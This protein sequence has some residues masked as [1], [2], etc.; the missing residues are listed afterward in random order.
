MNYNIDGW[1]TLSRQPCRLLISRLTC[2]GTVFRRRSLAKVHC[3]T[4]F[5]RGWMIVCDGLETIDGRRLSASNFICKLKPDVF[6]FFPVVDALVLF[7]E[8]VILWACL[9]IDIWVKC[10]LW[11]LLIHVLWRCGWS[12][13]TNCFLHS[14]VSFVYLWPICL[15]FV[16]LGICS[17]GFGCKY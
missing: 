2:D 5:S 6:R 9:Q 13:M 11:Y 16:H 8:N 3:R 14:S 10:I 1:C 15:G 7:A 17:P 12:L 4:V